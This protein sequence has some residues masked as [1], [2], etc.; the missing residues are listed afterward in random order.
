M[1]GGD[2]VLRAAAPS[3]RVTLAP[4]VS[5]TPVSGLPASVRKGALLQ[6]SGRVVPQHSASVYLMIERPVERPSGSTWVKSRRIRLTLHADR[7]GGST[8]RVA[9]RLPQGRWRVRVYHAADALHASTY[10]T[11][12]YARVR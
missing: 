3:N 10:S 12:R 9:L 11:A 7:R 8:W 4:K 6:L 2:D 1:F 5:L